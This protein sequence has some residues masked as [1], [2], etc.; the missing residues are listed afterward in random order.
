MAEDNSS[1]LAPLYN[2]GVNKIGPFAV[3]VNI[4]PLL[5]PIFPSKATYKIIPYTS[6]IYINAA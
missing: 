1:I 6:Y 5:F 4:S 3:K 2:Q